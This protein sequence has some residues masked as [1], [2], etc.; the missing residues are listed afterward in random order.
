MLF[1]IWTMSINAVKRKYK[2]KV[3]N[4]GGR[5]AFE[6]NGESSVKSGGGKIAK[7]IVKL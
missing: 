1:I 5:V 7:C 3:T 2:R 6:R 4:M